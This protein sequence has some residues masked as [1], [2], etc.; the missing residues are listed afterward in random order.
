MKPLLLLSLLVMSMCFSGCAS[1]RTTGKFMKEPENRFGVGC[2]V[3]FPGVIAGALGWPPGFI[4]FGI[5][6]ALGMSGVLEGCYKQNGNVVCL[7]KGGKN[8]TLRSNH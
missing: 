2:T 8:E 3:A 5:G 1:L 6:W 4:I 7:Q